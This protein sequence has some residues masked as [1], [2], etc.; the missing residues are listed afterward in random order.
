MQPDQI[1]SAIAD[2]QKSAMARIDSIKDEIIYELE[3]K[4]AKAN[5]LQLPGSYDEGSLEVKEHREAFSQFIRRGDNYG[6]LDL[7]HKAMAWS[8][9]SGAD[10]G[11]AVPKVIDTMIDD[12]LV[13]ISP[14]RSIASVVQTSTHDYHKL[15]NLRGT[16]SSWVGETTA[17]T[18]TTTP[19]LA[20]V[21]P[22]FGELY[23]NLQVTQQLLD[24][25]FFNVEEWVGQQVSTEFARAEGLAFI[26]GN[27]TNQPTGFL[28][29]TPVATADGTR[30]FGTLQYLPTGVAGNWPASNPG[31]FLLSLIFSLKAAHRQGAVFVMSKA[32]LQSISQFKDSSGRYILTPMTQPGIPPTIFGFPVIEAEDMPAIAASSFSVAFGNFKAGYIIVDRVGTR[33]LRDPFSNKPYVGFYVT[34][35]LAGSVIDSEAIK[36]AKFS[37]T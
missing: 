6:L 34:K 11:Y 4:E 5:R 24:D 9:N 29:G 23:S 33:V 3:T 10:G 26:S 32:T 35:R 37:V 17:R 8:S 36:L 21:Q 14:I 22:T 7:Q 16:A 27:G 12:L 1:Q 28:N 30:A 13:N 25:S 31:D 15:V 20:D 2:F 19:Q 18:A